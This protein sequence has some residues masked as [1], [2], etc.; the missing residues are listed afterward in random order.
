MGIAN[1]IKDARMGL[2][3]TQEHLAMQIGITKGAI[4]NY[5]NG[6]STPK[7]ALLYKLM[8]ALHVDA[9]YMFQD[10][11]KGVQQDVATPYEMH[12]ILKKYRVLDSY[13]KEAVD[14]ILD[15]EY[16]RMEHLQGSHSDNAFAGK[17]VA[18][19]TRQLPLPLQS[20]SA[21][22]G[23]YIDDSSAT[24][25]QVLH[26]QDTVKADYLMRVHGDSMEPKLFD[27]DIVLVRE[28]PDVEVG[29]MGI[30]I[31][32]NERYIKVRAHDHLHSLNPSYAD[33]PLSEEFRCIGLV[34]C[35]LEEAWIV[36]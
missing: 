19:S 22:S 32:G 25:I 27:N 1:R 34:I 20:S 23:E 10:E 12:H 15:V 26:N 31:S 8:Q 28:Q 14:S 24:M 7:T 29:E 33:I 21:G 36:P 17:L 2:G 18:L 30:F 4:A 35:K 16:R 5:E 9:N 13:G 11:M 3:L 6:V